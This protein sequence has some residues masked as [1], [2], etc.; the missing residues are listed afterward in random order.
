MTIDVSLKD[1]LLGTRSL[2]IPTLDGK[3]VELPLRGVTQVR[4]TALR[5]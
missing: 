3:G 1:A 4:K 2:K 5:Q